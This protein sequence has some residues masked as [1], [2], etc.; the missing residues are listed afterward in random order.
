[1]FV[2]M[3]IHHPKPGKSE[4]LIASMHR[5]GSALEGAAGLR[6]VHTLKDS[7]TGKLIG[8]AIWESEEA[9][10]AGVSAARS[11]VEND[12]FEDWEDASEGFWLSKV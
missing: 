10:R 6:E 12:P 2:H 9:F 5:F 11:A 8:L 4:D 3:S 7:R 1:M